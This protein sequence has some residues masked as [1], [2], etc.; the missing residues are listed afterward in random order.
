MGNDDKAESEDSITDVNETEGTPISD[1]QSLR[2]VK[3]LVLDIPEA[4]RGVRKK[5]EIFYGT[6]SFYLLFRLHQML[7]ERMQSAKFHSSSPENKWKILNDAHSAD[8]Y[9]RFKC[10]LHNLLDG[11]SDSMK[12]EDECRAIVGAQSYILFTLDKLIH[13]LIKQMQIIA[14]EDG[15]FRVLHLHSYERLRNPEA[16]SDAVYHENARFLIP[17][18]NLYRFEYFPPHMRIVIRLVKNDHHDKPEP[19]AVS[20]DPS[21]A[22][23]LNHQLLSVVPDGKENNHGVFME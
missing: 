4:L 2:T 11:T 14:T 16:F 22:S 20:M 18:D 12:F 8:P 17:D 1:H 23:Y 6:D 13:K 7:Y 10:A 19:T 5:S 3:P 9:A 21:F 15:E